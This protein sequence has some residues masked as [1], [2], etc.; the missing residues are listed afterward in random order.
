MATVEPGRTVFR[1]KLARTLAVYSIV[2]GISACMSSITVRAPWAKALG[3]VLGGCL[4]LYGATIAWR[5]GVE[6]TPDGVRIHHP[7]GSRVVPWSEIDSF[8]LGRGYPWRVWLVRTDGSVV[9]IWGLGASGVGH[10][11]SMGRSESLVRD[12]NEVVRR[13]RGGG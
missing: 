13:R 4:V 5:L 3:A 12:L 10:R 9:K 1:A 8:T 7:T 11:A 2:V 6:T